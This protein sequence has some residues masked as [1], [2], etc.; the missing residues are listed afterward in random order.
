MGEVKRNH[1]K[2]AGF[3][4]FKKESTVPPEPLM[5][6]LIREDGLYD[7]PKGVIEPGE[8][9]LTAAIREC[10]E[11]CSITVEG[12]DM[13][14]D[15]LPYKSGILSV[16]CASTDNTPMIIANPHT[17]IIE[18]VG[19]KWVTK[20]DFCTKCLDFLIPSA[21]HFYSADADGYNT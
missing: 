16:F 2:G 5:L 18:H 20:D 3:L 21:L 14:F 15:S 19:F 8:P 10:F 7:I 13:L 4:L 11:E 9:E 12:S 17:G 1:R 6:A